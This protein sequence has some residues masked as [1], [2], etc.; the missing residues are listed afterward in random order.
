MADGTPKPKKAP[1]AEEHIGKKLSLQQRRFVYE[2][3]IDGNGT[4]A[5]IRA[6]Y[7]PSGAKVTACRLLKNETIAAMIE[8]AEQRR[9][10]RLEITAD[11]IKRELAAVAFANMGDFVEFGPKTVKLK[12]SAEMAREDLAAISEVYQKTGKISERGIR[13]HGKVPALELLAKIDDELKDKIKQKHEVT[14][15]DGGPIETAA[16]VTIYIPDNGRG[17]KRD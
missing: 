5:A 16:T 11:R 17:D 12:P 9:L 8:A 13:L 4:A 2:Y 10:K 3:Q 7:A 6:G 15:K 14:G 1:A